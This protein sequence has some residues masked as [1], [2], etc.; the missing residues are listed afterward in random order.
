MLIA[1]I[2]SHVSRSKIATAVSMCTFPDLTNLS[3]ICW[4][5]SVKGGL[6]APLVCGYPLACSPDNM[7]IY[8]AKA[9]SFILLIV[10]HACTRPL[11]HADLVT[12]N[13]IFCMQ[14][15]QVLNHSLPA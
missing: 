7:L 10:R 3:K 2:V 15:V 12:A 5:L 6:E 9:A 1:F 11:E 13:S 8:R 4:A 14:R